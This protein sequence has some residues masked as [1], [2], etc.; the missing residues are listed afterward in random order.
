MA[1]TERYLCDVCGKPK[2]ESEE[3]WVAMLDCNNVQDGTPSQP[4]VKMQPWN[5][6]IAHSAEAK[7][8]CGA[9]C[10]HKFLDRW[11]SGI[12]AIEGP[13]ICKEED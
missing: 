9:V 5:N 1:W 3:W 8:I 7:H 11:M 4:S 13:V 6:L 12:L 2:R 10:A